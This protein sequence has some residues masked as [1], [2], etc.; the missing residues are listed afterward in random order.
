MEWSAGISIDP[1]ETPIASLDYRRTPLAVLTGRA[2]TDWTPDEIAAVRKFIQ[3]GGH[4]LIDSCGGSVAFNDSATVLLHTACPD[5]KLL[6]IPRT[7]ALFTA[8]N[9]REDL[10]VPR[11]R[12]F[13][14]ETMG[15]L[16]GGFYGLK[17]GHGSA[18]VTDLDITTG[19][20]GTNTWGILGYR[21]EYATS[22]VKNW[23]LYSSAQTIEEY[24]ISRRGE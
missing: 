20:L 23:I 6:R 22:L 5:A 9:G 13:V 1:R 11:V 21:P 2:K 12:A 10:T 8:E 3:S 14:S 16:A 15:S 4:L 24:A 17:L 19:L 18:I 7:D